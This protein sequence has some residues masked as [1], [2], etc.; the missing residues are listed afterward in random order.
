[1]EEPEM[2][3][4]ATSVM[5]PHLDLP[6]TCG[7]LSDLGYDG[8]E[9]RVRRLPPERAQ[10][11]PSPWG[12]HLTDLSPDNIVARANEVKSCLA[13]H[14]LGVAAFASACDASDLDHVKLLVE[15]ALAVES[16]CIRLGCRRYD[17]TVNYHEVYSEAVE[18]YRG[19]LEI[20]SAASVK[21]VVEMHGGTIHPSASLAHRIVSHF[22]PAHIGVVYDPQNMVKD[23]FE[24]IQLA[25]EVLGPYLAHAH[26]GGHRPEPGERD[27]SG[28]LQWAWSGCPMRE[29]LYDYPEMFR[30]LRESGYDG[31][32][33]VEDFRG[34]C[35][36][37]ERLED[38]ITYL[39]SL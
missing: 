6:Q 1:M 29:G 39:R 12:R 8:I 20:T 36:P 5:L 22:D 13:G 34:D 11:D 3:F 14:G 21:V 26:V 10:E 7:L 31:Y 27:A 23:G 17:G 28:T 25:V 15:G 32:I 9:L 37:E 2:K 33:S 16:P 24:T 35:S 30:H 38:A 19:A 4:S 18:H